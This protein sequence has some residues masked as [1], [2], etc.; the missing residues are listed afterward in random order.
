M[1]HLVRRDHGERV[2]AIEQDDLHI[3]SQG[4]SSERHHARCYSLAETRR[5]LAECPLIAEQER[6]RPEPA[7]ALRPGSASPAFFL[8]GL[9]RIVREEVETA[10]RAEGSSLRHVS[11][12]GHLSRQPGLSYSELGRRAGITAQSMQA[13]LRQLEE[14][15]AVERRTLPG[16]GRTAQLHVTSTGI[17]MLRR[18]QH[19]IRDADQRLL[20]D[21]P[22][23]QQDV[24]TALLLQA[25]TAAVRRRGGGTP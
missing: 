17:D 9:G 12:L 7:A 5:T 25:F 21:I 19:A 18:G 24:L 2:E 8:I 13:T 22:G 6:Q 16:R 14:L 1:Q 20:A 4:T 10:L 23:D 11:A 15:G 3:R